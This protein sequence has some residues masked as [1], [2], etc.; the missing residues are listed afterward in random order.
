MFEL[1]DDR[2]ESGG[3]AVLKRDATLL[4]DNNIAALAPDGNGRLWVGYFDRGLEIVDINLS[5]AG[6]H[7]EDDHVYCVNRI[8]HDPERKRTGVATANGFVLFDSAGVERQVLTKSDG[9]IANHV[10]DAL[11]ETDGSWT[12]GTPAGITFL[13]SGGKASSIY[14]MQGL[15]NNHVYALGDCGGRMVAGTLGGVSILEQGLIRSSYTTANSPLKQNWITAVTGYP[16][17]VTNGC[18]LGTYGAG[19]VALDRAGQWKTFPDMPAQVEINPNAMASTSRA[20]YAGT[21]GKGLAVFDAARERW[22]F[23]TAGLPSLNVT[24]LGLAGNGVLYIGTDN[25]LVRVAESGLIR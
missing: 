22:T 3:L 21:L 4:K 17:S 13:E 7:I 16:N 24:A 18:F 20:V 2:L 6:Q 19:V 14:A 12:L 10:T 11:L 5:K 8:V 23:V 15:V 9:L 1:R 25:G